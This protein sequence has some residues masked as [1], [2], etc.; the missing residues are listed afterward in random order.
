[1]PKGGFWTNNILYAPK[2]QFRFRVYIDGMAFE[3]DPSGD[4][5]HDGEDDKLA[6]YIKSVDKPTITLGEME[7]GEGNLGS[8]MPRYKWNPARNR[9]IARSLP[10]G[11]KLWKTR[12]L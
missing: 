1:M 8:T 4:E 11:D 3:D 2:Q 10:N 9:G 12:L 7:Q 5:Y 6:W